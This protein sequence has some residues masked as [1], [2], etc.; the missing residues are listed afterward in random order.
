MVTSAILHW[1]TYFIDNRGWENFSEKERERA[2]FACIIKREKRIHESSCSVSQLT[3]VYL[4]SLRVNECAMS[5]FI[6]A[7]I[8]GF[9]LYK[10]MC[11]KPKGKNGKY[12]MRQWKF[13][14]LGFFTLPSAMSL[15]N[16]NC[17]EIQRTSSDLVDDF[18]WSKKIPVNFLSLVVLLF[19][20]L[21]DRVERYAKVFTCQ[22]DS[23]QAQ[24]MLHTLA[25]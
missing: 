10:V 21:Q 24:F 7:K 9:I 5:F 12:Q 23:A 20:I 14:R 22:I 16:R 1:L 18:I 6:D 8:P 4:T 17:W 13:M 11:L 3:A 15:R 25:M 19:N 2:V